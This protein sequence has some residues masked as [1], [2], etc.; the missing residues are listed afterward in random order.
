MVA[1]K[2]LGFWGQVS[3]FVVESDGPASW[4]GQFHL[5]SVGSVFS[6]WPRTWVYLHVCFADYSTVS[7]CSFSG[8]IERAAEWTLFDWPPSRYANH[9][10]PGQKTRR[11]G[12]EIKTNCPSNGRSA[13]W[14][15]R[16]SIKLSNLHMFVPKY[17]F[18]FCGWMLS[19]FL[20][21]YRD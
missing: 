1:A 7:A 16:R 4:Y 18:F 17:F 21:K 11:S 10:G 12:Q 13:L 19:C 15:T 9:W 14:K 2:Y 5:K 20:G 3:S 8:G 6:F